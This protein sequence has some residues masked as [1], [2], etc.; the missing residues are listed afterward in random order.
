MPTFTQREA[1]IG[2]DSRGDVEIGNQ[3]F[4]LNSC[5]HISTHKAQ[6][7]HM[8]RKITD[9]ENNPPSFWL[10]TSLTRSCE[11]LLVQLPVIPSS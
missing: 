8:N 7:K 6:R 2:K 9:R 4:S 1:R 3:H 10:V 11:G 5:I